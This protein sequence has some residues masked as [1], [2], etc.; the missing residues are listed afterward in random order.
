M[1]HSLGFHTFEHG[2]QG[3]KVD[4]TDSGIPPCTTRQQASPAAG[5]SA[6]H[7][8]A[9]LL[10]APS[11]LRWAARCYMWLHANNR[12]HRQQAVQHANSLQNQQRC[13]ISAGTAADLRGHAHSRPAS[14]ARARQAALRAPPATSRRGG[15]CERSLQTTEAGLLIF[16]LREPAVGNSSRPSEMLKPAHAWWLRVSAQMHTASRLPGHHVLTCLF[17]ST[18]CQ[19]HSF[20]AMIACSAVGCGII[21]PLA[22]ATDRKLS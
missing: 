12:H 18:F 1:A 16:P 10:V 19:S 6:L 5:I 3:H 2:F 13:R 11:C 4:A 14:Q 15:R 7:L 8:T 21:A 20:L 9:D 22:A 17:T